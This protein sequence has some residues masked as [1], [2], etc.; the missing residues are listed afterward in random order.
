MTAIDESRTTLFTAR[1]PGRA[2]RDD[3]WCGWCDAM[4]GSDARADTPAGHD[5]AH[6]RA[7]GR[8]GRCVRRVGRIPVRTVMMLVA[9]LT[10]AA[11]L[12]ARAAA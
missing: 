6:D 1:L 4:N 9:M 5:D 2:D 11:A 3:G 10:V 7:A 12:A 8:P